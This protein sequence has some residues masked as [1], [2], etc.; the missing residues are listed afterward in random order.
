M[1]IQSAIY[2]SE[3]PEQGR[4][5]PI[6][7]S[8]AGRV[9]DRLPPALLMLLAVIAVELG[10]A[11]ATLVFTDLGQAGTALLYTAFAAMVFTVASPPRI[12]ARLRRHWLLVLLFG[13]ADACMSLSF[14]YSLKHDIP[15]GIAS[16]IAFLGPL[17]LAVITS[18][19]AHHFLWIGIASLGVALL[20]PAIGD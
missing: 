18:R 3:L 16:T 9:F 5:F 11:V 1:Y 7:R 4:A 15:L 6:G 12:D 8:R 17:G 2:P 19:R 14:L 13:L 20:T 10:W